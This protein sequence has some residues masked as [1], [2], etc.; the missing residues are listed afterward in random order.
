MA[1]GESDGPLLPFSD[2]LYL[3][4][5]LLDPSFASMWINHDVLVPENTKEVVFAMIKD[6]IIKEACI[7]TTV[8]SHSHEQ[9]DPITVPKHQTVL[10]TAY[11]KQQKRDSSSSPLI[12]FNHYL[13][14]C[15][16]Q[17]SLQ[18]W[19][20]NRHTLPSLFKVAE[21]VMAI[22]ASSAP[23]ER[24]FSHGGV[25]MQ[26]HRSQLS[27]KVLSNLIFCKCNAL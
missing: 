23:V 13:D 20:V 18:F 22:P 14:I 8:S 2:P 25:I 27:D 12:Q 5:A 26:P 1:D 9:E 10:F 3:K 17:D 16:G 21:R 11:R 19:A 24:V 4:A 6:L 7:A 15:D